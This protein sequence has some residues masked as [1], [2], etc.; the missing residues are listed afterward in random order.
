M[1]DGN[2]K[3]AVAI[4]QYPGER[5]IPSR[6]RCHQR[7]KATGFHDRYAW[8]AVGTGVQ[9]PNSQEKKGHVQGEEEPE[10][11]DGGAEGAEDKEEGENEP[12]LERRNVSTSCQFTG[13]TSIGKIPRSDCR[14]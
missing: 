5:V 12:A 1:C 8:L 3:E 2:D 14:G 7:K 6:E 10:E 11:S 4:I 13:R 9:V